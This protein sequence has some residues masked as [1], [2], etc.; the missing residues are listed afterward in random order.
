M[1]HT[2]L[3]TC[4]FEERDA[5]DGKAVEVV[6]VVVRVAVRVLLVLEKLL[7]CRISKRITKLN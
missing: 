5:R 4:Q 3:F 2:D 7:N 6:E 1:W